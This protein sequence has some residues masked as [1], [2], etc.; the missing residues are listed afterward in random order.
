M[1]HTPRLH[2]IPLRASHTEHMMAVL[3]DPDLY[4]FIGGEP[5]DLDALRQRYQRQVAGSPHPGELWWNWVIHAP[6]CGRFVGYVQV[7]MTPPSPKRHAEVAWVLGTPGRDALKDRQGTN[8]YAD[9]VFAALPEVARK[10]LEELMGTT[11]YH[12]WRSEFARQYAAKGKAEGEARALLILL[13]SRGVALSPANRARVQEFT[14]IE[15]L[16][17]WFRLA[18]TAD[19][20]AEVFD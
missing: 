8:L 10:Y 11:K 19:T 17:R 4:R 6:G 5:S 20:E 18:V 13:D 14:E 9:Y 12:E 3:A 16:D 1:I 2:L 15:L 7:T